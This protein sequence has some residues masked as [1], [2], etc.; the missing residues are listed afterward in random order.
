[1]ESEGV[2]TKGQFDKNFK[3]L[4]NLVNV[5][6]EYPF[7]G[8]YVSVYLT[9]CRVGCMINRPGAPRKGIMTTTTISS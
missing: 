7:A 8:I 1:M 9:V 3:E 5:P 4:G 6:Y 2:S